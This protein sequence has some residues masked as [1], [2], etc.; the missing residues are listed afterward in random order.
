[1]LVSPRFP[2][3]LLCIIPVSSSIWI[4]LGIFK[5]N[6]F[7]IASKSQFKWL[8]TKA[9][10]KEKMVQWVFHK[11][12][13]GT[14]LNFYVR[15]DRTASSYCSNS[16]SNFLWKN[17]A[18]SCITYPRK[19]E[20]IIHKILNGSSIAKTRSSGSFFEWNSTNMIIYCI[21]IKYK[22]ERKWCLVREWDMS[23]K[24]RLEFHSFLE[25]LKSFR[26]FLNNNGNWRT[27]KSFLTRMKVPNIISE[28]SQQRVASTSQV[29]LLLELLSFDG[30]T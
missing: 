7:E 9:A 6:A 15:Y 24:N 26:G 16:S 12:C 27:I 25:F 30:I 4:W 19:D 13:Y 3:V 18:L 28:N 14:T 1:M 20:T 23:I 17:M 10:R 21:I 2:D 11:I 22:S 29:I 5:F 8:M